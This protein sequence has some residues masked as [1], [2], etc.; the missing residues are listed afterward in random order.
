MVDFNSENLVAKPAADIVRILILESRN[1][2]KAALEAYKRA[3][4]KGHDPDTYEVGARLYSLFL[5]LSAS[6][7]K[8]V[9]KERDGAT[10]DELVVLAESPAFEDLEKAY[11]VINRWLKRSRLIE[12][13]TKKQYDITRVEDANKANRL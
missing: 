11:H 6:L 9:N 10:Y 4:L 7:E 2:L 13:N 5:E 1:D 3:D 12:V 8:E